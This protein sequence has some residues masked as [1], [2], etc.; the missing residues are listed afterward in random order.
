MPKNVSY[1]CKSANNNQRFFLSHETS[2][3]LS[4]ALVTTEGPVNSSRR[5]SETSSTSSWACKSKEERPT[6]MKVSFRDVRKKDGSIEDLAECNKNII[7]LTEEDKVD[8]I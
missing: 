7:F 5:I 8:L 6:L 3:M 2:L 4:A 1:I